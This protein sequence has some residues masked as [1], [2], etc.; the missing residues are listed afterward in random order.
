MT[1]KSKDT[2]IVFMFDSAVKLWRTPR[3][4]LTNSAMKMRNQ[5][6]SKIHRIPKDSIRKIIF[7]FKMLN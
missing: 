4:R 5:D 1:S 3:R 2:E 7:F 6:F